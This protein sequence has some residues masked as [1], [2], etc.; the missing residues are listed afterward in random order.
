MFWRPSS[1]TDWPLRMACVS[2]DRICTDSC[3][4]FFV[5]RTPNYIISVSDAAKRG[6]A[7][8]ARDAESG[9]S[10]TV[11][12]NHRPVAAII[13]VSELHR[14]QEAERDLRDL[15]VVLIRT[16]TDNGERTSLDNVFSRFGFDRAVLEREVAEDL[17]AGRE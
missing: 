12:R 11:E 8:L 13:G 14:Y 9:S 15:A 3:I 2:D 5:T 10:I 6:I 1:L 7:G 16:A 4:L 17:A